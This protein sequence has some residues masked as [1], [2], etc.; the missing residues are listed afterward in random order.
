MKIKKQTKIW[1]TKDKKKIRICDME[2]SHL[3]NT[4]KM[5]KRNA[6][7]RRESE[8]VSAY[9]VASTFQGDMATYYADQEIEYMEFSTD[10]TDFVFP[11]FLNLCKDYERRTGK[12][13]IHEH[14]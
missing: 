8:I 12:D 3:E 1:I 2:D 10:W 7:L 14:L 9:A 6:I 13:W 5:L 11:I 4:L